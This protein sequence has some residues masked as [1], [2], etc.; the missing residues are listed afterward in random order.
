MKYKLNLRLPKSGLNAVVPMAVVAVGGIGAVQANLLPTVDRVGEAS[1]AFTE[2]VASTDVNQVLATSQVVRVWSTI[3]EEWTNKQES[4]FI[5]LAKLEAL[6]TIDES[7][8]IRLEELGE[9]RSRLKHR[10]SLDD[11]IFYAKQ[12]QARAELIEA[13][14]RFLS[15]HNQPRWK[16][17]K[18]SR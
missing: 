8:R 17:S 11:L 13:M 15:V 1:F 18:T 14:G 16:G 3:D 9:R 5:R 6:D 2:E 4:E 7:Q 12:E 10:R